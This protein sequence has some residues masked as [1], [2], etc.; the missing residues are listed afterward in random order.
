MDYCEQAS[1]RIGTVS[2]RGSNVC[3]DCQEEG[4]EEMTIPE[5]AHQADGL[6]EELILASEVY[7]EDH[8]K[9]PNH[10]NN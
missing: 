3:E 1:K 9:D 8:L 2:L 10:G 7:V 5:V 6:L 4:H